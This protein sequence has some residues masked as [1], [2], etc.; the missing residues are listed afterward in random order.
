MS[1]MLF[2]SINGIFA[3]AI[4]LEVFLC[5]NT[6]VENHEFGEFCIGMHWRVIKY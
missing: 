5:S 4:P 6:V 1:L 3:T 2:V